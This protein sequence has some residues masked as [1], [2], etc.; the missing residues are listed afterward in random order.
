M[1]QKSESVKRPSIMS[2]ADLTTL[3]VESHTLDSQNY[4]IASLTSGSTKSNLS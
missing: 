4:S 1:L 3:I 2:K